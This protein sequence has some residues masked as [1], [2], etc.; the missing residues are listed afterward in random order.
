MGFSGVLFF[1]SLLSCRWVETLMLDT[2]KYTF[3][4][5]KCNHCHHGHCHLPSLLQTSTLNNTFSVTSGGSGSSVQAGEQ[6]YPSRGAVWAMSHLA[7]SWTHQNSRLNIFMAVTMKISTA[8]NVTQCS[9]VM[10]QHTSA[11]CF[12]AEDGHSIFI[13]IILMFYQIT[14]CLTPDDSTFIKRSVVISSATSA[15]LDE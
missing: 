11:L 1:C 15:V 2:H 8:C 5:S 9:L 4:S 3:N 13:Q 7:Q 6:G 12:K 14:P 10:L